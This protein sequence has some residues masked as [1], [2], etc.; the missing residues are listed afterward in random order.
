MAE[1]QQDFPLN[2]FLSEFS[3]KIRDI[4]EK[5]RLVRDRLLLVGQNLIET[6]EKYSENFNELI[7][8]VEKLKSDV[9][10]MKSLL[11]NLS[12]D[13]SKFARKEELAILSRQFK[14]FNPLKPVTVKDVERIVDEKLRK[15]KN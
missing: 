12:E 14:M 7:S 2:A 11:R 13:Y 8:D 10:R 6:K 3:A 1:E 4:E 5:Q 9:I 15:L